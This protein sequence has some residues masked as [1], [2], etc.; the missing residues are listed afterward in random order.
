MTQIY[1]ELLA[2]FPDDVFD[3]GADETNVEGNCTLENIRGFEAKLMAH[4]VSKGKRP[5]GWE[6]V[7]KNTGAAQTVPGTIVRVYDTG[8]DADRVHNRSC[9][10][11][12]NVTEAGA[13]AAP[14]SS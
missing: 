9:P 2:L 12:L 5:A 8:T 1:D 10:L 3:I 13:L 14:L 6:Q 4:I 11:L 7:Y